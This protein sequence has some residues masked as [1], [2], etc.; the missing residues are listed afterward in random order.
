MVFSWCFFIWLTSM[1]SSFVHC[2]VRF[3]AS[4]SW[5]FE[6]IYRMVTSELSWLIVCVNWFQFFIFSFPQ[7]LLLSASYFFSVVPWCEQLYYQ[8]ISSSRMH[9]FAV[10]MLRL[11][12]LDQRPSR[13]QHLVL[14]IHFH[15]E[16]DYFMFTFLLQ[17]LYCSHLL[18]I[19][20]PTSGPL[21]G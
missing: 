11:H 4:L 17:C 15:S 12:V 8:H 2:I 1:P 18:L 20:V 10:V 13:F 14:C 9:N 5:T 6:L 16:Q 19:N 7:D 21:L 3:A